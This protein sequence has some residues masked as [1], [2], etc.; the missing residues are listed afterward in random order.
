M[1]SSTLHEKEWGKGAHSQE[2]MQS[3]ETN[4]MMTQML[5]LAG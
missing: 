5:E 1:A 4:H 3:L 2:K